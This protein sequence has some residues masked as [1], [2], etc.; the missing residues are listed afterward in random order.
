MSLL[1]STLLSVHC[2]ATNKRDLMPKYTITK[3][4][5]VRQRILKHNWH[6]ACFRS[7]VPTKSQQKD[8]KISLITVRNELP[9]WQVSK[10]SPATNAVPHLASFA[11]TI[12]RA[13]FFHN[14]LRPRRPDLGIYDDSFSYASIEAYSSVTWP[15][16]CTSTR[17]IAVARS[18]H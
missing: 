17:I 13:V 2:G 11:N 16:P 12:D 4:Q 1:A 8:S 9:T 15:T 10:H 5:V 3:A 7:C 14:K 18:P 6:Q